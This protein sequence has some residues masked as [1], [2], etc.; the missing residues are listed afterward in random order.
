MH[1]CNLSCREAES[2]ELTIFYIM[3]QPYLGATLVIFSYLGAIPIKLK[4]NP[5]WMR[6]LGYLLLLA[7]ELY[8]LWLAN[9]TLKC[10]W[11]DC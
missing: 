10:V 3:G 9:L 2:M 11:A 8:G 6:Y 5:H 1:A 4:K 7:K